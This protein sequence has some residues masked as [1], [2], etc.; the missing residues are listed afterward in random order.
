MRG[1]CS[2]TRDCAVMRSQASSKCQLAQMQTCNMQKAYWCGV[3]EKVDVAQGKAHHPSPS[4]TT[5]M[6]ICKTI[7]TTYAEMN[8]Y[9]CVE[10]RFGVDNCCN[11]SVCE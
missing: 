3:Q 5:M 9:L 2:T 6:T 8:R 4:R 1:M 10:G 7:A 11:V